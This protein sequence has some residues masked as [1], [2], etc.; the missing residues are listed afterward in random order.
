MVSIFRAHFVNH[1]L[2]SCAAMFYLTYIHSLV[3][4]MIS[5]VYNLVK[6]GVSSM[7]MCSGILFKANTFN[8][9]FSMW[10]LMLSDV[11]AKKMYEVIK[12]GDSVF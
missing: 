6:L 5:L 3:Q 7:S 2:K 9:Y 11:V 8:S 10:Y 1:D 12:R 4:K